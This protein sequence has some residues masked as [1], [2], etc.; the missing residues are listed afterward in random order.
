VVRSHG[1][2]SGGKPLKGKP[3]GRYRHETRPGGPGEEEIAER[4]RNPEGET[5]SVR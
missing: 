2:G 5:Y 3:H 4:V 1:A